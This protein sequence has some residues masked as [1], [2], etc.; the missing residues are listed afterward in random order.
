MR[1]EICGAPLAGDE[2]ELQT[3]CDRCA[4]KQP[5][6]GRSISSG[7]ILAP[8][9][10]GAIAPRRPLNSGTI[11]T[12]FT[13]TDPQ[14]I[15][16]NPGI[17][18]RITPDAPKPVSQAQRRVPMHQPK[19]NTRP[20]AASAVSNENR[21][22]SPGRKSAVAHMPSHHPRTTVQGRAS[23][24]LPENDI[25][26]HTPV[27]QPSSVVM[28]GKYRLIDELGRGSMGT[29]FL[30]EDILL[31]RKVAVKFLLP[32]LVHATECSIRF[33][34]EA[35][36]MAS[37]RNENVAQIYSY[38]EDKGTPYF[39]MEYLEGQTVEEL[40]DAYNRRGLF[41][42]LKKAINIMVQVLS[43]VSAIHNANSV[44]RDIKPGNIMITADPMRAVIMD[45]GLVRDIKVED[46]MRT[47][48]GT[49]AY[50]APELV[51]GKQGA[52][53]S[54]L[55]DIYSLGATFYELIT[56]VIPFNGASWVE[57]LQKHIAEIPQFP[58]ILRPG[59]PD[60]FDEVILRAM[61]KEPHERFETCDDFLDA[62]LNISS[63]AALQSLPRTSLAP[64]GRSIIADARK[65]PGGFRRNVESSPN[66]RRGSR[67]NPNIHHRFDS[68]PGLRQ[69]SDSNPGLYRRSDSKPG[70][71]STPSTPRT[72]PVPK[73]STLLVA[74]KDTRFRSDVYSCIKASAPDT[75]IHS[76]SDG[77]MTMELLR[78]FRPEVLVVNLALPEM[79]GF[80]IVA[81]IAGETALQDTQ[82]IVVTD[83]DTPK[84]L[85]LLRAMG[86]EHFWTKPV[87]T[88]AMLAT[89]LPLL[90][91]PL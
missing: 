66:L 21:P 27:V 55:A 53:K 85:Q 11:A 7:P 74:D 60:E 88:D 82:I 38:G 63:D 20:T 67:S 50:I 45:F 61:S 13:R 87:N 4:G 23:L 64:R 75:R 15:E 43:G 68:S 18:R 35:I 9:R 90:E 49:P 79:N 36:A 2:N 57:I 5:S 32:E 86:V 29:V 31:R 81:S 30:A 83:T 62:L 25:R 10:P 40:I 39:V 78:T 22:S 28:E 47:L 17:P 42:P 12:G 77:L 44:H 16:Q 46:D 80:E 33:K 37:I 65:S 91:P 54:K 89:M 52:S 41:T 84:D 56:G 14:S 70:F 51:E 24:P 6:E 3:M 76:A 1:C 34:R 19:R 26:R 8:S 73:N 59:L 69:G 48:A 72:T 71:R 58:S